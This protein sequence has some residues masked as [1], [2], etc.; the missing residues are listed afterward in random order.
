MS[1]SVGNTTDVQNTEE[2]MSKYTFSK[3]DSI[4]E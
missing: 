4:S 1:S 3:E 2:Y